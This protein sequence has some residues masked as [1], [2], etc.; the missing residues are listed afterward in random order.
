MGEPEAGIG[1]EDV[2]R[3]IDEYRAEQQQKRRKKVT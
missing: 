1:E 3:L 2:Q